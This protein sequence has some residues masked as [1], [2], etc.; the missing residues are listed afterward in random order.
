MGA[1][2]WV[3]RQ[4]TPTWVPPIGRPPNGKQISWMVQLWENTYSVADFLRGLDVL[5]IDPANVGFGGGSLRVIIFESIMWAK[6]E[7][8][9][10]ELVNAVNSVK[11]NHPAVRAFAIDAA[12]WGLECPIIIGDPNEVSDGGGI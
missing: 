2:E 5:G 9:V 4:E 6:R 8:R 10:G 12:G 1:S 11:P 7:Q 3:T